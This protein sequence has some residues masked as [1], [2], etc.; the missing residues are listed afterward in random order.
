M[1]ALFFRLALLLG[2]AAGLVAAPA[3]AAE[4]LTPEQKA[5]VE[6]VIHD[7]FLKH[8]EFMVEVLHAAQAKLKQEKADDARQAIAAM[9]DELLHD[10]S[11][12]VGGNPEGDV[13]I[14]EF[15][16]YRCPYCKQVEPMLEALLKED[17][18][19]R[20]VYKEFPVLGPESIYATRIALAAVKQG[21]YRAFHNAM[22]MTK[23]QITEDVILKV[24]ASAGVDVNKAK[25]DM[26][27][28]EILE[29][30]KRN[31]ALAEA[32]DIQG[33]PAFI[34]GDA[35]L[36]GATDIEHLK[37]LVADARKSG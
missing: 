29:I 3:Q 34:I 22:M 35:L 12:P 10:A 23:G 4:P 31:F 7:Y 20:I 16:D 11:A 32:L 26:N 8:P 18:K 27:A 13:T 36:P 21:K 5:A 6:Q 14:V 15:F 1:S 37:R 25:A 33:T 2:L 24:A 9:R 30:I 28:P 19:L 17:R